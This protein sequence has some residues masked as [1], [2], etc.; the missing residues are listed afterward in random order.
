MNKTPVALLAMQEVLARHKE[1][2]LQAQSDLLE[3][4]SE[5]FADQQGEEHGKV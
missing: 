5:D 4:L 2:Y 1:E 3:A